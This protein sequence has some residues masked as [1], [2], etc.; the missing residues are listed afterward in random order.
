MDKGVSESQDVM[1]V[2]GIAL[3]VKLFDQ[4]LHACHWS[5]LKGHTNSKIVTSIIL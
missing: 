3:F 2:V 1:L 5:N 4:R